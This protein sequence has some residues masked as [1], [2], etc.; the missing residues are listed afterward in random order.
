M[1]KPKQ[2]R[3]ADA[4]QKKSKKQKKSATAV[5]AEPVFT[6]EPVDPPSQGLEAATG[7]TPRRLLD[8]MSGARLC[9]GKPVTAGDLTVVPVARVRV[10]G[11]FGG[12]DDGGGGGGAV[13]ASPVGYIE[14]GADGASFR[15]IE[16][17]DRAL[18]VA[19]SIAVT[20]AAALGAMAAL[21]SLTR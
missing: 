19:R 15:P 9:Y 2:D 16:D 20:A 3:P 5:P 17:P 8:R 4:K 10:A 13:E 14:V 18:R 12:D 1:A 6:A 7:L 21:R 11:G